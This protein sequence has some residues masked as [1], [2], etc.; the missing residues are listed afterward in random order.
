MSKDAGLRSFMLGVYNKMALG[1]LITAGIAYAMGAFVPREIAATIYTGPIGLAIAFG[2]LALLLISSFAM[3]NPSPTG[4]N[5]LYWSIVGLIGVGMGAIL[6]RF[7]AMPDGML[8]IAKA[9]L[10]TAIAFGGLSLWGYTTKRDLS[11]WGTFLIMGVIGLIVVS[12]LNMFI[13]QSPVMHTV[14]SVVGLLLF[15]G[16]TAYDTQ[17]LKESYF[18]IMGNARAMSVATTFGALSLYINFVNMFQFIL[19]LMSSD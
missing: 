18:A 4:A 5:L 1:L 12:L 6:I 15:A 2:P 17:R 9:F 8:I 14:I 16:L 19:S 7:A 11:G 10:T 3:R 13:F